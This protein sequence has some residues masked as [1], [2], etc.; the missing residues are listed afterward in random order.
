MGFCM[1]CSRGGSRLLLSCLRSCQERAPPS[2]ALHNQA[3]RQVLPSAL[4]PMPW[5]R[6]G[7]AR[8]Q[9]DVEHAAGGHGVVAAACWRWSLGRAG[10][11]RFPEE[12]RSWSG[13]GGKVKWERAA[14]EDGCSEEN[15]AGGWRKQPTGTTWQP[16]QNC[17]KKLWEQLEAPSADGSV[18]FLP[19]WG[20][21]LVAVFPHQPHGRKRN[22]AWITE[23]WFKSAKL[24]SC[25]KSYFRWRLSLP[26]N[27]RKPWIDYP[28][29]T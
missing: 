7:H 17:I 13:K 1:R 4:Q 25:S 19:G 26:C 10:C 9:G 16:S 22:Q 5:H 28:C 20:L 18:A 27:Y 6:P 24:G 8:Q 14:G 21:V 23:K 11:G 2:Q 15:C 3:S 12:E 29:Q